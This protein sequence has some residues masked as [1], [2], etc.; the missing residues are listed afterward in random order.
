MWRPR[1]LSSV[2]TVSGNGRVPPPSDGSPLPDRVVPLST[3][4]ARLRRSVQLSAGAAAVG[5]SG[6]LL[7][8]LLLLPSP[9]LLLVLA[10]GAVHQ[11]AL[12]FIAR[13]GRRGELSRAAVLFCVTDWT[14]VVV[15]LLI[16]PAVAPALVP[17]ILARVVSTMPYLSRPALLRLLGASIGLGVVVGALTRL[18]FVGVDDA[19]PDWVVTGFVVVFVPVGI[20]IVGLDLWQHSATLLETADRALT[21]NAGLRASRRAL[22]EQAEELRRSRA[23]LVAAADLERRRV[24]R[25]LHDG[26][27]QTLIGLCLGVSLLAERQPEGSPTR[28]ELLR[29]EEVAQ[30][31]V[32]EL[33]ELAHGVYPPVLATHGLAPALEAVL[34]RSTLPV[35]AEIDAVP[36]R[37][38]EQEAAV[39]FCCR[40]ALQN[41]EKHA[42]REATVAVTLSEDAAGALRFSVADT[43][44][45]FDLH[46]VAGHGLVNM[47]DRL[48]AVGGALDVHSSP[49]GT[50]VAGALP[51]PE[52]ESGRRA[53]TV[54][55]GSGA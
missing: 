37:P 32:A 4:A 19:V 13:L 18:D 11:A 42:G 5:M 47:R 20:A 41:V 40:E 7:V 8:Y 10:V 30:E 46:T 38:P 26:A 27:Q 39:Y 25:D 23:R 21:A 33:R 6:V 3:L 34:R 29:L 49:A 35:R 2:P 36:R 55:A 44:H 53:L 43:G 31:A 15:A 17:I 48:A 12:A 54:T 28:D 22:A 24:E 9:W 52:H 16:V 45:G 1:V 14:I 50:L 51:P